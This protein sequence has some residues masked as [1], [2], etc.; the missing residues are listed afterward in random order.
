MG[1]SLQYVKVSCIYHPFIYH[2][3][4]EETYIY[5]A[6]YNFITVGFGA[7]KVVNE[8]QIIDDSSKPF[9]KRFSK[10]HDLNLGQPCLV[11]PWTSALFLLTP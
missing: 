5:I 1:N 10:K 11:V 9:L 7:T 4:I 8:S 2:L 3:C 6:S